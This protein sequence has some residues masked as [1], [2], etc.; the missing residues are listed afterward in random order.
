MEEFKLENDDYASPLHGNDVCI[1]ACALL[2]F[3]ENS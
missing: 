2:L 1:H 3:S